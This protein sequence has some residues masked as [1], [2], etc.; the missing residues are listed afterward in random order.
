MDHTYRGYR[1]VRSDYVESRRWRIVTT[2][3]ATGLAYAEEP[4][5]GYDTLRDARAEI[6]Y[7]RIIDAQE[8]LNG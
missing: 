7:W 2:H 6:D 5:E 1:I 3:P 8:A 4:G